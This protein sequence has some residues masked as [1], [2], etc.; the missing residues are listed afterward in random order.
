MSPRSNVE[1]EEWAADAFMFFLTSMLGELESI[2][3]VPVTNEK[4]ALSFAQG[5]PMRRTAHML[6]A[7]T[8]REDLLEALLPAPAHAPDVRELLAFKERHSPLMRGFRREIEAASITLASIDDPTL[9]KQRARLFREEFEDEVAKISD[10]TRHR[11]ADVA[12]Y[13]IL[14]I[15][16]SALG[17]ASV[18]GQPQL[19]LAAASAPLLQAAFAALRATRPQAAPDRPLAYAAH[20]RAAFAG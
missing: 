14:P 10:A 5:T 4:G 16:G 18:V 15:L 8:A 20:A 9:R 11:W 12:F 6:R 17:V 3:A 13:R 2:D 19:G 1:V 7:V